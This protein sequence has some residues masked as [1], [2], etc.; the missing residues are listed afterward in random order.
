MREQ[1]RSPYQRNGQGRPSGQRSGQGRPS[2]QRSGQGRPPQQRSGR[3]SGQRSGSAARPPVRR[4]ARPDYGRR[5]DRRDIQFS[6]GYQ[7]YATGEFDGIVEY[8]DLSAPPKKKK[9]L[10][11]VLLSIGISLSVVLVAVFILVNSL[12]SRIDYEEPDPDVYKPNAQTSASP[13]AKG[14]PMSSGSGVTNFLLIGS[15]AGDKGRS[16]TMLMLSI[17]KKNG[18]IKMTSFLRDLY[19]DIPNVGKMKMNAAFNHGGADRVIQTIESN[20]RVKIDAYFRIDFQKLT[21][22]VDE[23]GGITCTLTEAEANYIQ[24][25]IKIPTSPGETRLQGFQSLWYCRIRKL[26]SDF[27]RTARQRNF[28][29]FMIKDFKSRGLTEQYDFAYKMMPYIKARDDTK[30]KMFWYLISA[31]GALDFESEELTVPIK[32][33]YASK[34]ISGSAVLVP[35]VRKNCDAI[36]EFLYPEN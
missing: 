16:D 19:V 30:G 12:I 31:V 21:N 5:N 7:R 13:E 33:G 29:N 3:P 11:R 25:K 26:D 34:T 22:L 18:K 1:D 6:D 24:N 8:D 32:N 2:Q 27:G 20:F 35:D 23:V 28:I 9:T 36:R 17:D 4:P 10:K 15:D 14:I